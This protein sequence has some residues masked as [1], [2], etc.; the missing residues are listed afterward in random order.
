LRIDAK[1]KTWTGECR[2]V[3]KHARLPLDIDDI[4]CL[5]V[6]DR[7]TTHHGAAA[8]NLGVASQYQ[9]LADAAFDALRA[10]ESRRSIATRRT[11]FV[12]LAFKFQLRS[13]D[14]FRR[15]RSALRERRPARNQER[16]T[17]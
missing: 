13:R 8:T 5:R 3:A 11:I 7:V 6:R 14:R 15:L 17:K 4:G 10:R 2:T 9:S 12:K 1:V 16:R